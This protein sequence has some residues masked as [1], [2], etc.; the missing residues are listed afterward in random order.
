MA[1]K[2]MT[3]QTID[4]LRPYIR[5]A[6]EDPELRDDVLAAFAAARDLYEQ[7]AKGEG[8]KGKAQKVSDKDF[9]RQLQHLVDD[10][11]DASD[12]IKGEKEHKARNRMILLTGIA[13]GVLYNPWTGPS[14]R[15]W[16]MQRISGENGSEG[17]DE[18][19]DLTTTS[20]P[21]GTT[22]MSSTIE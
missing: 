7:V 1:K 20:E 15:E 3:A 17:F 4:S 16:I 21:V 14:T 8:V 12:R 10:L 5:R 18:F 9:Q 11:S 6:I 22:T 13:L 19:S 2:D